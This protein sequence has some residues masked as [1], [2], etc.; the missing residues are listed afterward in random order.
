MCLELPRPAVV[1]FAAR[2]I[3]DVAVEA[4]VDGY[5]VILVESQVPLTYNRE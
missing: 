4:A 5:V 1:V 2:E 3:S